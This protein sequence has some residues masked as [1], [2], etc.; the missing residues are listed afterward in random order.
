MLFA[1]AVLA[2]GE[3]PCDLFAAGGTPCVAA[4]SM[5]RALYGAYAGPLYLVQRHSDLATQAIGVIRPGGVAD[6]ASQD[7]FC[8][9]TNC[10][11]TRFFD[12]TQKGNH[13]GLAPAG[14]AVKK[15][16]RGVSRKE[17]LQVAPANTTER[18]MIDFRARR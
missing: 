7:A 8:A 9:G 15:A 6:A 5:T 10:T 11:V 4:H 17:D 12:Q 3:G 1:V 16:D 14:G 13:L 18:R 2:V